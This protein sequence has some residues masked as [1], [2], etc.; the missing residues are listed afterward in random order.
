MRLKRKSSKRNIMLTAMKNKMTNIFATFSIRFKKDKFESIFSLLIYISLFL[1]ISTLPI[2]TYNEGLTVITN[3]LSICSGSLILIYL[4]IRR[5]FIFNY[6]VIFNL[7]FLLYALVITLCTTKQFGFDYLKTLF[8][9]H[10]F[11]IVIF[12]YL[13][14]KRNHK[15]IFVSLSCSFLLLGVYF[16]ISNFSII[17]SNIG[18][19]IRIGEKLGNLNNIGQTFCFGV[20]FYLYLIYKKRGYYYFLLIPTLLFVFC[21]ICTGSRGA[22]LNLFISLFV[23][24]FI[25]IGKRRAI[26]LILSF[27]VLIGLFFLLIQIPSLSTFKK[28]L[29][30]LFSAIFSLG[31]SNKG[32]GSSITRINMFI[33]G[34]KLWQ[35]NLFFGYGIEGFQF[36]TIYPYYSHNTISEIFCS[37]GIFGAVFFAIPYIRS[38]ILNHKTRK[39]SEFYP[40]IVMLIIS[41]FVELF[42][43]I[44]FYNKLCIFVWCYISVYIFS[45]G[46]QKENYYVLQIFKDKKIKISLTSHEK[47]TENCT[48]KKVKP[49]ISFVITQLH[50]GGAEKVASLLCS[51]WSKN[52]EVNLILTSTEKKGASNYP[53]S[54]NVNLIYLSKNKKISVLSKIIKLRKILYKNNS[55]VCVT[56]FPSSY[57]MAKISSIG[58]GIKQVYSVR[59]DPKTHKYQR[60][61]FSYACHTSDAI[62][63]QTN[64]IDKYFEDRKIKKSLIIKN[65]IENSSTITKSNNANNL[66][67]VGRLTEQK[68]FLFLLESVN[69]LIN[70]GIVVTLTIYGDGEQ[71][72]VLTN[73]ILDN[74]LSSFIK[75]KSFD[76]SLS[77]KIGNYGVYCC[78]SLYE[79]LSNSMLEAALAGLPIVSLDCGGGSAK[80]LVKNNYNGV[81]AP[82][83]SS[84]ENFA[85]D[86]EKVLVEYDLFRSNSIDN[87]K[88][89]NKIYNCSKISEYWIKLFEYLLN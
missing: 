33:D 72:N 30:S 43:G 47:E 52:Y 29:F 19:I 17:L 76:I 69:V 3:I 14:D 20:I 21:L 15:F 2:F 42:T 31:N 60:L 13:A 62:V 18:N 16:I 7:L 78:S 57:F 68:N 54:S 88:Y 38:I 39:Q 10:L 51:E 59:N 23:F 63:C 44:I 49:K 71:K 84:K 87:I 66:V 77:K 56:F 26:E 36:N 55:N 74:N 8:T 45:V 41:T 61:L 6:Y 83:D 48:T 34:L 81:L 75:L 79:G 65:P 9:T 89:I 85:R 70:K 5:N 53:I 86:I 11:A 80:E 25:C 64:E 58:Y 82:L 50:G 12:F 35:K 22:Y 46:Y 4:I 28:R 37:V 24:L 73:Y 32:D 40:L 27:I 1:T 67:A